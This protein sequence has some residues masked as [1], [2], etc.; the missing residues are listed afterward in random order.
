MGLIRNPIERIKDMNNLAVDLGESAV[1][2]VITGYKSL[3]DGVSRQWEEMNRQAGEAM[4][5]YVES[6]IEDQ[7][8]RV[9]SH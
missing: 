7:I 9:N 3:V 1:N 8:K 5:R 4:E 6:W 2:A